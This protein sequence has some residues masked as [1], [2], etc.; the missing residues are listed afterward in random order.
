MTKNSVVRRLM[1]RLVVPLLLI[2]G[3]VGVMG[4]MGAR[5][6]AHLTFDH[7]LVDTAQSLATQI[8]FDQQQQAHWQLGRDAETILNFDAID[9]TFYA[10][11]QHGHWVAGHHWLYALKVP[12]ASSARRSN[13]A[14]FDAN[15]AGHDVRVALVRIQ[16]NHLEAEVYVAETILKREKVLQ[17]LDWM[18]LPLF[19]LL[20]MTG[21]LIHLT[22]HGTLRPLMR[23]M[24]GWLLQSHHSIQPIPLQQVPKEF[25][26]LVQVLNRLFDRIH[27]V[28]VRERRFISNAAHQIRTPLTAL[29]LGLTRALQSNQADEI[30]Q[31]MQDLSRTTQRTSR[32]LQQLLALGRL[33]PENILDHP[34]QKTNLVEFS[35]EVGQIYLP[36]ALRKEIDLE[37]VADQDAVW[38]MTHPD[39]L[40]EALSN[41]LDN[42]IR[43]TP[44]GGKVCLRVKSEP[45][46]IAVEDSGPGIPPHLRELMFERFV[47]GSMTTPSSDRS[48][49][50]MDSDRHGSGLGLSIAQ[51]IAQLHHSSLHL[52][53]SEWGGL[54]VTLTLIA[55]K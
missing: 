35:H 17:A 41:L 32:L 51:E 1:L 42:A 2:V 13:T 18:L 53:Q 40:A 29:Q 11:R 15:L 14:L 22:V 37:F 3:A 45:V 23:M 43:Y 39:L 16:P 31:V 5:Y 50:D 27:E 24:D 47:R 36:Y 28:L 7:W 34:R 30:H 8:Q 25:L 46:L 52:G 48:L 44:C 38:A 10:L 12:E 6:L 55:A 49:S 54:A 9:H 21:L 33:D 19:V 26:P 4:L 20:L